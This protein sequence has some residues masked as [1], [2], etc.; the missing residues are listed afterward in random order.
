MASF[1]QNL[2]ILSFLLSSVFFSFTLMC[3]NIM[4]KIILLRFDG[5]FWIC[6][7]IFLSSFLKNYWVLFIHI[8][9]WQPHFFFSLFLR[10]LNICVW[11][12]LIKSVT[13]FILSSPFSKFL[14]LS[15]VFWTIY[16]DLR[17]VFHVTHF[18]ILKCIHWIKKL[19][20]TF[21]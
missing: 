2:A 11:D 10:L 7:C 14:S 19:Y 3:Q 17:F 8:L 6:G 21:Y 5:T 18:P 1:P 12:H 13:S 9:H 4:L 16:S 20:L 15:T